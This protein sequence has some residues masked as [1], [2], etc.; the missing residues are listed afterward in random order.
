MRVTVI[1]PCLLLLC[2]HVPRSRQL[3][4]WTTQF[5]EVVSMMDASAK[6]TSQECFYPNDKSCKKHWYTV[7]YSG[8]Q[9]VELGCSGSQP[10]AEFV[11]AKG[12]GEDGVY[13]CG[14]D[15]CNKSSN[16]FAPN[17]LVFLFAMLTIVASL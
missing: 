3:K 10:A 12:T 7:T 16:V 11:T 2:L 6:I 4:C 8:P 14:S 17:I 13:F 1:L 5:G 9:M 15:W